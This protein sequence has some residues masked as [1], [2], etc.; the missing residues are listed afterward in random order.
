MVVVHNEKYT[1]F[2]ELCS[3]CMNYTI[4]DYCLTQKW[5]IENGRLLETIRDPEESIHVKTTLSTFEYPSIAAKYYKNEA[6]AR[7][8]QW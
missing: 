1:V 3:T 4:I 7:Q 2:I 8:N 6:I 5:K